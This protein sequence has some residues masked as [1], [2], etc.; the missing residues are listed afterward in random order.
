MV[1][2]LLAKPAFNFDKCAPTWFFNS[3]P[4][5][6]QM[7]VE[8]LWADVSLISVRLKPA[9]SREPQRLLLPECIELVLKRPVEEY[10]VLSQ[11]CQQGLFYITRTF[12]VLYL[13]FPIGTQVGQHIYTRLFGADDFFYIVPV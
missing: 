4:D 5:I 11:V 13:Q 10:R 8:R 3:V 7:S 9:L 1:L 2:L 6:R 12:Y